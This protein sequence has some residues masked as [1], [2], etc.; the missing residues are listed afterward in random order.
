LG[1]TYSI[2]DTATGHPSTIKVSLTADP[3][4]GTSTTAFTLN[5]AATTAPAGYV[6]DVQLKQPGATA[7][8]DFL[9]GTASP[10][11]TFTPDAGVGR[12]A[13]RT[14]LRN[15]ANGKST[16]WSSAKT[17]SVS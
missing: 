4:S 5:W 6:Y 11:A 9:A 7:Y 14:R 17:I 16:G 3:S 10:S 8:M 1:R 12:Y 13:F 15:S 2:I